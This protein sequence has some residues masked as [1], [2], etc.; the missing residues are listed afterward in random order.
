MED[1]VTIM[2][3]RRHTFLEAINMFAKN[4]GNLNKIGYDS[5]FLKKNK[6]LV[7]MTET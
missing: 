1:T 7:T 2:Y 5:F 6:C 4:F 3:K